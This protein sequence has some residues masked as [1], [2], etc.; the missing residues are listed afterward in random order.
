MQHP[1]SARLIE[2]K[3]T[4]CGA[5]IVQKY[6]GLRNRSACSGVSGPT[7]ALG[8]AKPKVPTIYTADGSILITLHERSAGTI[9]SS[10]TIDE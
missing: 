8:N 9:S 4:A 2:I 10:V 6:G 3:A 5:T 7:V 1:A